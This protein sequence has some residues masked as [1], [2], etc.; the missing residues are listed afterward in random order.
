MRTYTVCAISKE[1]LE[2][3]VA[4]YNQGKTPMVNGKMYFMNRLFEIHIYKIDMEEHSE[5]EISTFKRNDYWGTDE[6]I[7]PENL[8][9][10]GEDITDTYIREP[11]KEVS[12][13][14]DNIPILD[15][16]RSRLG[17]RS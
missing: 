14:A 3:F 5:E 15:F 6:F 17:C 16:H 9:K 2:E 8:D 10:F 4:D 13:R 12:I 7:A 1:K 11:F